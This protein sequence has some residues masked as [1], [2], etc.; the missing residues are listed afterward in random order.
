MVCFGCDDYRD[1][2]AWFGG[3]G[4]KKSIKAEIRS[5]SST[6]KN[7]ETKKSCES[8]ISYRLKELLKKEYN[9]VAELSHKRYDV[10]ANAPHIIIGDYPDISTWFTTLTSPFNH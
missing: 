1:L 8:L 2:N 9:N 7:R 3:Q 10:G 4:I 5:L 6:L